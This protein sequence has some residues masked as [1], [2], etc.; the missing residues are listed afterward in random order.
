METKNEILKELEELSPRLAAMRKSNPF[1]IPDNYFTTLHGRIVAAV[2]AQGVEAELI[3]APQLLAK[4][5]E[6]NPFTVPYGYFENFSAKML[7]KVRDEKTTP[8]KRIREYFQYSLRP[9]YALAALPV[10]ALLIIAIMLFKPQHNNNTQ[11]AAVSSVANP[12]INNLTAQDI[13]AYL[14]SNLTSIDEQSIV[15]QISIQKDKSLV[16]Q[17]DARLDVNDP[18]LID[19]SS[20]DLSSIE[21]L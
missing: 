16:G 11:V 1:S 10:A 12:Q 18:S 20:V 8:V 7:Q 17:A 4:R 6:E 19:V 13:Q 15:E 9:V 3:E 14:S 5:T 21:N 2:K